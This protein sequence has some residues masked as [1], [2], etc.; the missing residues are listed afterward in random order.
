MH[1]GLTAM[2]KLLSMGTN[3]FLCILGT[4]IAGGAAGCTGTASE[5][6]EAASTDAA[7]EERWKVAAPTIIAFEQP[8]DLTFRPDWSEFEVRDP[9]DLNGLW[10]PAATI[11]RPTFTERPSSGSAIQDQLRNGL[12]SGPCRP[13]INPFKKEIGF[14]CTWRF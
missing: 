13:K 4:M 11:D 5:D 8:L 2:S 3:L 7:L 9:R 10:K 1:R 6:E 14:K 12:G